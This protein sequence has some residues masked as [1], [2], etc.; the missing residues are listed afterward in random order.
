MRKWIALLTALLL[1]ALPVMAETAPQPEVEENPIIQADYRAQVA[2]DAQALVAIIAA[3]V[4]EDGFEGAPDAQTA[5]NALGLCAAQ[6]GEDGQVFSEAEMA[7]MYLDLFAEGEFDQIADQ[8][9]GAFTPSQEGYVFHMAGGDPVYRV[10]ANNTDDYTDTAIAYD[11]SLYTLSHDDFP[12]TFAGSAV[13]LLTPSPLT[14]FGAL[15]ARWTPC[16]LPAFPTA[17]SGAQLGDQEG[18]SYAPANAIDGKLDTCW[19]YPLSGAEDAALT[20]LA[21][22]PQQVRGLVITPGYA[23]SSYAF[24]SNRR[25][26]QLTARLYDGTEFTWNLDDVDKQFYDGTYVLP[27][28]GVYETDSVTIQVKET[29]EGANFDDVCISEIYLF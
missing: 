11:L 22:E 26:A 14:R 3:S 12:M 28:E 23:K 20:L 6:V 2:R 10:I 13:A 17:Q 4:D 25:L 15:V 29:Y 7:S 21:D 1:L 24:T 27:F 18:N 8:A 19:A 5:W 16:Q 9:G